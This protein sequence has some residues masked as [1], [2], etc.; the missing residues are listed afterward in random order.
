MI[1][2]AKKTK[3]APR[4]A[5]KKAIDYFTRQGLQVV[6]TTAELTGTKGGVVVSVSGST[7]TTK[8]EY[9]GIDVAAET[10]EYLRDHFGFD[11][12]AYTAHLHT[13][14]DPSVGHVVVTISR[15]KETEI[16][17]ESREMDETAKQFLTTLPG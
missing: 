16:T 17:V 8:Q 12:C 10:E 11:S 2:I 14:P 6:D 1:S 15:D 13:T 3:L 9:K 5:L 4:D 7:V